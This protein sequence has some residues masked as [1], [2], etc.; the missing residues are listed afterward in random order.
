VRGLAVGADIPTSWSLIAE[1]AP[2]RSRGRMMGF[3]NIFWY[4][5][6]IAILRLSL[7][8]GWCLSARSWWRW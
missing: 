4:V 2:R 8:F 3:M 7:A 6:P 5:G 1:F